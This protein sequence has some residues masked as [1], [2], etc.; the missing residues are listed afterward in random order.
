MPHKGLGTK[1]LYWLPPRLC[2]K[3]G[4]ACRYGRL[5]ILLVLTF[6][7]CWAELD[8]AFRGPFKKWRA[9]IRFGAREGDYEGVD[10]VNPIN[11]R[12][13]RPLLEAAMRSFRG[14]ES[15]GTM[16]LHACM[17]LLPV[18]AVPR[19]LPPRQRETE[20]S[21]VGEGC[22]MDTESQVAQQFPWRDVSRA[23]SAAAQP[24]SIQAPIVAEH[25]SRGPESLRASSSCFG[26]SSAQHGAHS[27]QRRMGK[28]ASQS[29]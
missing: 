3:G 11:Q 7:G 20:S 12:T 10:H 1:V 24:G 17:R 8:K 13:S 19:T 29:G 27:S 6:L 2:G 4:T 18:T 26:C 16:Q 21:D 23:C 14:M 9:I 25:E 28:T 5:E 15:G 22:G